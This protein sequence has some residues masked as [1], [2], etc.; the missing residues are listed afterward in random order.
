MYGTPEASRSPVFQ[1]T[2]QTPKDTDAK[3]TPV[4][5][6]GDAQAAEEAAALR[7]RL[8]LQDQARSIV[9]AAESPTKPSA[10]V[11][12]LSLLRARRDT[13]LAEGGAGAPLPTDQLPFP[14][15][16][17][18]RVLLQAVR[19]AGDAFAS[20]PVPKDHSPRREASVAAAAFGGCRGAAAPYGVNLHSPQSVSR[21]IAETLEPAVSPLGSHSAVAAEARRLK[22]ERDALKGQSRMLQDSVAEVR[23]LHE[24]LVEEKVAAQYTM[25]SLS[26]TLDEERVKA[27]LEVRE[28]TAEEL[29]MRATLEQALMKVEE[30]RIAA[31]EKRER[32]NARHVRRNRQDLERIQMSREPKP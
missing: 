11:D 30:L 8:A 21:F 2:V 28:A 24:Q 1:R 25:Q 14:Q 27:E 4:D 31:L 17:P 3:T 9:H 29:A 7:C 32:R 15:S 12:F 26:Q 6:A 16:A 23:A 22:Q 20:P 13:I 5:D 19:G 10:S 18:P